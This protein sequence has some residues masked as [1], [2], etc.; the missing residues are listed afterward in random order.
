MFSDV[1]HHSVLFSKFQLFRRLGTFFELL[2][3]GGRITGN[4]LVRVRP[5]GWLACST[6]TSSRRPTAGPVCTGR[7]THV[8]R[9]ESEARSSL[10]S[11]FHVS[12]WS[13]LPLFCASAAR[14]A[15]DSS[16][17][18][19]GTCGRSREWPTRGLGRVAWCGLADLSFEF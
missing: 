1:L 14:G 17:A 3:S 18:F 2:K 19:L 15:W 7:T 4:A 12:W 11:S 5:V 10:A 9:G 6:S 13:C 16:H 8:P